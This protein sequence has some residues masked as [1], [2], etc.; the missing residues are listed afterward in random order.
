MIDF[1]F[2][3]DAKGTFYC[4]YYPQQTFIFPKNQLND[5]PAGYWTKFRATYNMERNQHD[6]VAGELAHKEKGIVPH[7]RLEHIENGIKQIKYQ[8]CF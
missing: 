4:P 1:G 3:V 6:I 2:I 7:N 5:Y 8:V